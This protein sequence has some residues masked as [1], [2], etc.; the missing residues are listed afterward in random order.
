MFIVFDGHD[1]SGKTSIAKGVAKELNACYYIKN[2]HIPHKRTKKAKKTLKKSYTSIHDFYVASK[3]ELPHSHFIID[4]YFLSEWVY[5]EVLRE[6]SV[7]EDPYYEKLNTYV[8][9]ED[10]FLI[11]VEAPTEDILTRKYERGENLVNVSLIEEI[12]EKYREYLPETGFRKKLII[13]NPEG[14]LYSNIS[15]ITSLIRNNEKS[16]REKQ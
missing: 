8:N 3:Q 5:S 9:R 10:S 4:R 11:I 1:L 16:N 14:A 6:E 2:F 15:T 13:Q 12:K 7:K